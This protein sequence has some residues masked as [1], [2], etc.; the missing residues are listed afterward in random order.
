[1]RILCV[2]PTYWPAFQFGG[3]VFSVHALNKALAVKGIS[4]TV[5]TTALGLERG[6]VHYKTALDGVTVEYFRT[7]SFPRFVCPTGWGFSTEMIARLRNT[8][9]DFDIVYIVSVWNFP[10]AAAAYF[11]RK[12]KV[13]YIFSPRGMLYPYALGKKSWKKRPYY[14]VIAKRDLAS[15]ACVHYTSQEEQVCHTALRLTNPSEVVSNG[16]SLSDFEGPVDREAFSQKFPFLKG[17]RVILFLGRI[18]EKKG[19][20]LLIEAFAKLLV[21]YPDAVLIIAGNDEAGFIATVKAWLGMYKI[22]EKVFFTGMLLGQEK[23]QAFAA[24]C[25]FVLPSYSENFGVS[26]IEAMAAGAP[27]VMSDQVALANSAKQC[28]AAIVV[29]A[30]PISLYNGLMDVLR[31]PEETLQR[32]ERAKQF[33][34]EHFDINIVAEQ[35]I[36]FFK[37]V[38]NR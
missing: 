34:R 27:V 3:P 19:L 26:I 15:A 5:Y 33:V 25:M 14:Q 4:I 20:D 35:M 31:K 2:I 8:V 24:C 9:R 6:N 16:I 12:E 11:C 13:P 36:S 30:T 37:R 28:Q 29:E 21:S 7:W 32:V 23:R 17:K 22:A 1:M 38:K 10:A 18:T